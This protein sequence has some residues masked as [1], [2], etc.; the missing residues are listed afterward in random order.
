MVLGWIKIFWVKTSEV[1]IAF[2]LLPLDITCRKEPDV[3]SYQNKDKFILKD[4]PQGL[5]TQLK[6]LLMI[7][8]RKI[9]R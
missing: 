4:L 7:L 3:L 5:K 9:T 2:G 8:K 6:H 1:M